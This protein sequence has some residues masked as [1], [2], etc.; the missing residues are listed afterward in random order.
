MGAQGWN[1]N[2]IADDRQ[3]AAWFEYDT[4]LEVWGKDRTGWW[5]WVVMRLAHCWVLEQQDPCF[6]RRR[7]R[8]V[9]GFPHMTAVVTV[10]RALEGVCGVVVVVCGSGLLFENY[11]VNASIF[12]EAISYDE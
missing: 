10:M 11:I 6:E 1:I 4:S 8:V 2:K 7:G 9:A 5:L 3:L 12:K